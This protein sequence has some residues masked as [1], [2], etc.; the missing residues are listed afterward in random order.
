MGNGH[1]HWA[2][3]GRGKNRAFGRV[4]ANA[5]LKYLLFERA[6]DIKGGKLGT[7]QSYGIRRE[8]SVVGRP[9]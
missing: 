1:L 6:K 2:W 7:F 9:P 3:H 4:L 5:F 8:L